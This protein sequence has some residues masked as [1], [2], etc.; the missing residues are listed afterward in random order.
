[1]QELD[2]NT[3][4]DKILGQVL[5]EGVVSSGKEDKQVNNLSVG[6]TEFIGT[7]PIGDTI[8]MAIAN[9]D[10]ELFKHL[11]VE[12]P[13]KSVGILSARSGG[14]PQIL[15]M[16]E[17]VKS[18]NTEVISIQLPRDTKGGA[19]HGSLILIGGNDVSDVRQAIST[20][21]NRVPDMFGDIYNTEAGHLEFQY[22]ARASQ[23]CNMAFGVPEGQAYGMV[24]G[25]PAGI[26]L[27]MADVAVKAA[28]VE[29]LSFA[30]PAH[31]TSFS[32]EGI[33]HITGESGAVKQ[34]VMS[35]RDVGIKL[36]SSLGGT[37][38]ND[39]PSYII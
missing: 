35:A 20:A 7:A 30:S 36:L 19:G 26:G 31:G 9:V 5:Q 14:G 32:N 15:A 1:M 33:L 13:F 22:T 21:L 12:K 3:L 2:K 38:T 29:V 25:A 23:A 18:T 8:G 10:P 6:V 4:V 39:Y 27:V 17:A 24:S 11:H 34:A 16:D 28:N 37:P